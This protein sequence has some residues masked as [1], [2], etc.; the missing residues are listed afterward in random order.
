M[1]LVLGQLFGFFLG[2]GGGGGGKLS[3]FHCHTVDSTHFSLF[4]GKNLVTLFFTK[5]RTVVM[6]KDKR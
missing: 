5:K 6:P 1:W 3:I 2:V 4:W